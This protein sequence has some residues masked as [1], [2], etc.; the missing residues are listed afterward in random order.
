MKPFIMDVMLVDTVS[1]NNRLYSKAVVDEIVAT[2]PNPI[3]VFVG[4]DDENP[5]L[6]ALAFMG[7]LFLEGNVLKVRLTPTGTE[8]AH[9]IVALFGMVGTEQFRA[10]LWGYGIITGP[11]GESM[12]EDA[13]APREK[14]VEV[15]QPGFQLQSI[16]IIP[17]EEWP[18]WRLP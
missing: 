12:E 10:A 6:L 4:R 18:Y 7:E 1:L 2:A 9:N 5:P 16:R 8:A 13:P 15:V 11:N 17:V 3:P 14:L